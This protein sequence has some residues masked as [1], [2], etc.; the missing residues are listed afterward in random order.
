MTRALAM[1]TKIRG[2]AVLDVTAPMLVL[3]TC[4]L[5]GGASDQGARFGANKINK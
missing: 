3:Q 1:R 2:N 4:V 5:G